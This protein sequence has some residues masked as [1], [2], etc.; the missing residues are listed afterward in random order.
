MCEKTHLLED[1]ATNQADN[2]TNKQGKSAQG[3]EI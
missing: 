2:D 3:K 1:I